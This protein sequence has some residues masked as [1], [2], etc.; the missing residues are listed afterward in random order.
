MSNIYKEKLSQD[1]ELEANVCSSRSPR[2]DFSM[3]DKKLSMAASSMKQAGVRLLKLKPEFYTQLANQ[4]PGIMQRNDFQAN[5][6][7]KEILQK[8]TGLPEK[9]NSPALKDKEL[10]SP[11]GFFAILVQRY[12]PYN[13]CRDLSLMHLPERLQ[14]ALQVFH[15]RNMD[16]VVKAGQGQTLYWLY[17]NRTGKGLGN[18]PFFLKGFAGDAQPLGESAGNGVLLS[19]REVQESELVMAKDANAG[20]MALAGIDRSPQSD[21]EARITVFSDRDFYKP[22]DTV[23]IAGVVKEYASGKISSPKVTSAT[24]EIQGPDWQKVKSDTLQLDRLG[25]FHYEYKSDPAGK[26]GHYQIDGQRCAC[27]IQAGPARHY[28]RLLPAEHL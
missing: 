25:G 3:Q 22:G 21:K 10:G 19:D 18:I 6:V 16:M 14:P 5:F 7:E 26:K 8:F 17:D 24:L 28:H 27:P 1:L 11:L 20:D 23:H 15:R 12:E 13:S 4:A 9:M 2:L